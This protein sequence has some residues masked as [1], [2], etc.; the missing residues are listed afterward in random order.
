MSQPMRPGRARGPDWILIGALAGVTL[1]TGA[2]AYGLVSMLWTDAKKPPPQKMAFVP[3]VLIEGPAYFPPP[4]QE[5]PLVEPAPLAPAEPVGPAGPAQSKVHPRAEPAV[6]ARPAPERPAPE[7]PTPERKSAAV[8]DA[9]T[10][11]KP[12]AREIVIW[13]V[14]A[15]ASANSMNLGGHINKAG[16]VDSVASGHLRDAL[17]AHRNFGRL[18]AT[19]R[20]HIQSS[21]IDLRRL[22]P[23]RALVGI[24]DNRI[25]A[26]HGIR[27]VRVVASR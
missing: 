19:L 20:A 21:N 2:A 27:F 13:R 11:T 18:P 16:I 15:T 7:R 9:P 25:E 26:E 1:L 5:R 8:E 4:P 24:D 23:Y 22:A 10:S 17:K 6:T 14:V 3:L 12:P